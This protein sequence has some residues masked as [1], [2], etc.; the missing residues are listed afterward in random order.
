M[1]T[2]LLK[3]PVAYMTADGPG[4][5][6]NYMGFSSAPLLGHPPYRGRHGEPVSPFFVPASSTYTIPEFYPTAHYGNIPFSDSK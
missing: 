2:S 5:M 4:V 1:T 3:Q 6:S